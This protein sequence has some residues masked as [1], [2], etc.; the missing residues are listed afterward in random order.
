M[1]NKIILFVLSSFLVIGII[2]YKNNKGNIDQVPLLNEPISEN[3]SIEEYLNNN[4]L[5]P[6]YGGKVFCVFN[7]YGSEE[8]NNQISYYLWVYCEEYYKKNEDVLI[9]SGVS[10][11]VRLNATKNEN[12]IEIENFQQPIDGEGYSKSIKDMFPEGYAK[13]AING[14]DISKLSENPKAKAY[15]F[16]KAQ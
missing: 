4:I 11:P 9:G 8:T 13:T 5:K 6:E 3:I 15:E 12:R 10:M 2:I 16:Y 1:K 7:K 14:F